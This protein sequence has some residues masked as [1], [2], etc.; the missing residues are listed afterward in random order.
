LISYFFKGKVIFLNLSKSFLLIGKT[1]FVNSFSLAIQMWEKFLIFPWK[2]WSL[3]MQ[4]M[5]LC[6]K[7]K[8]LYIRAKSVK[9]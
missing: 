9:K 6:R 7:K 5:F 3:K 4:K 1:F 8:N 2:E